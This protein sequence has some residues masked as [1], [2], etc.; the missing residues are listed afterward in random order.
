[1]HDMTW[2][3]HLQRL[4]RIGPVYLVG[5]CVRDYILGRP[6]ADHDL[7]VPGDAGR[8]AHKVADRLGAKV[9][10]IGK[11]NKMTFR[12]VSGKDVLDFA[13]MQGPC[14]EEDL[15]R[16]DFTMNALAY[17]LVG[18][19][20]IDPLGG[21][22]DI[23]SGTVRLVSDQALVVDPVRMIRAFR[24]SAHFNFSI[25]PDTMAV[26]RKERERIVVCPRERICAE[27]F[28]MMDTQRSFKW[29]Q[30]IA[31]TG[32]LALIIPELAACRGCSQNTFHTL[33]VFD[34]T[35]Q[36]YQRLEAVLADLASW[37]PEFSAAMA[38]Y[39]SVENRRVLLKWAA[40][41]H[42][43]GK[44]SCRRVETSGKIRFMGHEKI[45]A[46]TAAKI[47]RRFKMSNHDRAYITFM[48]ENH[49]RPLHLFHAARHRDLTAKG[50]VRFVRKYRD[51][52]MGLLIVAAADQQ[53]K[54][55]NGDAP[56]EFVSFGGRILSVYLAD[57]KP[58]M[59]M[60]RLLSG[61][62]LMK[63]FGLKPSRLI[64][65]ILEGLEEARLNGEIHTKK[66]A[67]ALAARLM[68]SM[69]GGDDFHQ[70]EGDAGIEPATPSSGGLCSIR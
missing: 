53:A 5:G 65:K 33:D 4:S 8:F 17:D 50:I 16:R 44:P 41:L 46:R 3:R 9:I 56:L 10:G 64:G 40:L 68:D 15:K 36:T 39:V 2:P 20:L 1:M 34:H 54:A 21:R 51:H 70:M 63:A 45:G 18:E 19:R 31:D 32:L 62:D 55:N 11:A 48:V 38:A 61:H 14:I 37:W 6:C 13:D 29:I 28:K 35:M 47:C 52:L 58:K 26:I 57:L 30:Q 60:P 67:L 49:L 24:F 7:V 12:V 27:L 22:N 43:I 66:E 25:A 23:R 59:N 69:A 42:D